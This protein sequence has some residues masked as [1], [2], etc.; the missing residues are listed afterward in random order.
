MTLDEAT[1]AGQNGYGRTLFGNKRERTEIKVKVRSVPE[2]LST[3][4][5]QEPGHPALSKELP[6]QS[7][8]SVKL[9]MVLGYELSIDIVLPVVEERTLQRKR[10]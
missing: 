7:S 10:G 5:T 1:M 9:M 8:Q 2:L 4:A 3:G 6:A